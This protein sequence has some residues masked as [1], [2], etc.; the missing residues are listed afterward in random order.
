MHS[1]SFLPQHADEEEVGISEHLCPDVPGFPGHFKT[2]W[3]DF[4]VHEVDLDGVE[5]HLTE[6]ITPGAVAA[7]LKRDAEE[8]REARNSLGSNFVFETET[9]TELED[10]VGPTFSKE[11]L[12]FL[13]Q[14]APRSSEIPAEVTAPPSYVDFNAADIKDGSKEARKKAHEVILKHFGSFLN[15]ETVESSGARMLRV[16]MREAEKKA[17]EPTASEQ[18]GTGDGA[19]GRKGKGKGGKDKK[20]RGKKKG[21]KGGGQVNLN[22]LWAYGTHHDLMNKRLGWFAQLH[23]QFCCHMEPAC[24][25]A[26]ASGSLLMSCNHLV[27]KQVFNRTGQGCFCCNFM[28]CPAVSQSTAVFK[29]GWRSLNSPSADLHTSQGLQTEFVCSKTCAICQKSELHSASP[30]YPGCIQLHSAWASDAGYCRGHHS[31]AH[32]EKLHWILR[33][34]DSHLV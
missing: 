29:I 1:A 16:W 13:Q 7:E 34:P 17:K 18:Q 33:V 10:A 11:L 23:S 30:M 26:T 20:G 14:Q 15:T 3:Q 25:K 8:R 4:H 9:E 32:L 5:L 2:R 21:E 31:P 28:M 12:G 22:C 19:K 6:L 24:S 27:T